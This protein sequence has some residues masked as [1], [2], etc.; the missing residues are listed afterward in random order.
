M[1]PCGS[2]LTYVDF[3]FLSTHS[4][5]RLVCV[6]GQ[7]VQE[8]DLHL[9]ERWASLAKRHHLWNSSGILCGLRSVLCILEY[10]FS[11]KREKKKLTI[12]GN[13]NSSLHC[14]PDFGTNLWLRCKPIFLFL[15]LLIVPGNISLRPTQIQK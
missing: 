9:N 8:K 12:Q 1:M 14:Q 3:Q 5:F 15:I 10:L 13:I 7:W 6:L 11:F 4:A 2:Q